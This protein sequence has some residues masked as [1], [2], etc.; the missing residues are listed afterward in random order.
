MLLLLSVAGVESA[1]AVVHLLGD[2]GLTLFDG[3]VVGA[4]RLGT[5]LHGGSVGFHLLAHRGRTLGDSLGN[6]GNLNNLLACEGEPVCDLGGQV[7]L[8]VKSVGNVK[9]RAGSCHND[10]VL[11]ESIDGFLDNLNSVLEVGLPDV[12][13]TN[14]TKGENLLRTEVLD[15]SLQLLG[16]ADE[17]DVESVGLRESRQDVDVVDDV[18]EVSGDNDLRTLAT[19]AS[20]SLVCRLESLLNLVLEIKDKHRLVNLNS[21]GTSL[22]KLLQEFNV[23]G[24]ELL[25]KCDG[26]DVLVTVGLSKSE[27]GNRSNEDRTSVDAGL[28]GL[29]EF[30][31]W[32]GIVVKLEGLV[33]LES[34][35]DVVV[36]GVK[37]LDHFLKEIVSTNSN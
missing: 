33:V 25:K 24:E 37:P 16:V 17:I 20:Q 19:K 35:L 5:S 12:T 29:E 36:V 1:L 13:S 22:F 8:A 15:N 31:Y 10:T 6:D 32:L 23:D 4:L 3:L 2:L 9:E 30:S 18:A 11:A 14:N 7:L 26:V 27:E 34:R 21:I 28:F